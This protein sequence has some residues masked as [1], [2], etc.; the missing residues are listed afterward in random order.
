MPCLLQKRS[1]LQSAAVEDGY[2]TVRLILKSE[3]DLRVPRPLFYQ[4]LTCFA[5]RFPRLPQ[6]LA[7]VGYF[8]VYHGHKLEISLERHYFQ[9]IA[10]TSNKNHLLPAVCFLVRD[11]VI[12]EVDKAKHPG[13]SGLKL[14]LGFYYPDCGQFG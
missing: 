11:Y 8:H 4:L 9:M 6:L 12:D 3:D 7:N 2:K 14:K 1:I 13:M 10:F 5:T